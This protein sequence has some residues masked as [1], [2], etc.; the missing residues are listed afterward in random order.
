MSEY[1]KD[2]GD[3]KTMYKN[4]PSLF[5]ETFNGL[6]ISLQDFLKS[7]KIPSKKSDW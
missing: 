3:I 6:N 2:N 4:Y 1:Y 7:D 5:S